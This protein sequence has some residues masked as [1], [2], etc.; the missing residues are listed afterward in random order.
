MYGLWVDNTY[1]TG[2]SSHYFTGTCNCADGMAC[3][4]A[5]GECMRSLDFD[6][7][8]AGTCSVAT[9]ADIGCVRD[10]ECQ[11]CTFDYC[12]L[13]ADRECKNCSNYDVGSCTECE[14]T[15]GGS[16]LGTGACTCNAGFARLG[17]SIDLACGAC[18]TNCATCT[19]GGLT[20]YSD[21]TSCDGT[22]SGNGILIQGSNYYCADYCPTGQTTAAV[23]NGSL[24]AVFGAT[25]NEFATSWTGADSVTL[26]A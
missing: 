20:N 5:D 11:S 22:A 2:D 18:H 25:F 23:C 17:N 19:T 21:C 1:L 16:T 7:Y 10:G 4:T 3:A 14:F 9:C 13:C 26:T 15:S 8:A 6:S 12:H 24:G